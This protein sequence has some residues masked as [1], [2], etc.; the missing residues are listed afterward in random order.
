MTRSRNPPKVAVEYGSTEM[1]KVVGTPDAIP[2]LVERQCS[3]RTRSV[4]VS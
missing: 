3:V 2:I 4:F 1:K